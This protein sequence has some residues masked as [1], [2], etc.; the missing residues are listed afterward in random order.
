LYRFF[1]NIPFV[2]QV[3]E[4]SVEGCVGLDSSLELEVESIGIK[5]L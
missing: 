1:G 4:V 5:S 2:P 3:L